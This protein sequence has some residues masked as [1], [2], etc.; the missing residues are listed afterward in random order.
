MRDEYKQR[1]NILIPYYRKRRLLETK[2]GK[3]QQGWFYRDENTG[4]YICS[5]KV[6]C[7]LEKDIK[8]VHDDVYVFACKKL[9]KE[10]FE[11][12]LIDNKIDIL[13]KLLFLSMNDKDEKRVIE[14]LTQG[15]QLLFQY[16]N[17]LYYG[18]LYYFF[19]RFKRYFINRSDLM[20]YED[21]MMF[22]SIA[23][24]CK[25]E[26]YELIKYYLYIYANYHTIDLEQYLIEKYDYEHS[27]LYANQLAYI[28]V[29]ERKA[30]Y[31]QAYQKC[32]V[33][34]EKLLRMHN[35]KQL[36][37]VYCAIIGILS[38]VDYEEMCIYRKKLLEILQTH[39]FT[40][41]QLYSLYMYVGRLYILTDEYAYSISCVFQALEVIHK[42]YYRSYICLCY[43][44]DTLDKSMPSLTYEID[45]SLGDKIDHGLY[46][47]YKDK[48]LKS[49]KENRDYLIKVIMP[50]LD[51]HDKL[52]IKI[53]E[54][55]LKILCRQLRS[56]QKLY[57]FQ[58]YIGKK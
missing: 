35:F 1:L 11:S 56:Y 7:A 22:D 23:C 14:L 50:L 31:L 34:E 29:Y 43:C 17:V 32:Q 40:A 36:A 37:Y 52:Y 6:Y 4:N 45:T 51:K 26:L 48:A 46:V 28:S 54:D 8:V 9:G 12:V 15:L 21:F 25:G 53:V 10:A 49:S 33:L 58:E 19:H 57:E 20:T 30:L 13:V 42:L 55:E 47:Y 39:E 41:Q 3:W 27:I 5:S 2:E 16:Q 24:I 18:E 44:F 38:Y